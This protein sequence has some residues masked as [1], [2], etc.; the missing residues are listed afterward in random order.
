MPN[1]L[2]V[3]RTIP[4]RS[5]GETPFSLTYGVKAVISAEINLCSAQVAGFKPTKNFELMLK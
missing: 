4:R 3:Y 1:V 5:T 2:W